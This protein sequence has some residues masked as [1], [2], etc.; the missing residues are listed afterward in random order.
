[1]MINMP[2]D[3]VEG[4]VNKCI[5]QC[6]CCLQSIVS[7]YSYVSNYMYIPVD[8]TNHLHLLWSALHRNE[9]EVL[10]DLGT[11]FSSTIAYSIKTL[12]LLHCRS[13]SI[14]LHKYTT[15]QVMNEYQ[16]HSLKF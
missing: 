15:T 3:N 12:A 10:L 5:F 1:M 14:V 8:L 13:G 6:I 16:I 4:R 7:P 11:G 9:F 2:I